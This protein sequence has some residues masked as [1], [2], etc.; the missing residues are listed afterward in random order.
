MKPLSLT[1]TLT[2]LP[3]V[4]GEWSIYQHHAHLATC[5]F[6]GQYLDLLRF[7]R[8]ISKTHNDAKVNTAVDQLVSSQLVTQVFL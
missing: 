1:V 2:L 6:W 3:S 8:I 7:L 4:T 5:I